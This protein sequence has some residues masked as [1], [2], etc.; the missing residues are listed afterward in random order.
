MVEGTEKVHRE[1]LGPGKFPG[2]SLYR[3]I[4]MEFV[5]A[6]VGTPA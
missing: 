3:S 5:D 1:R 6:A 2:P 4:F